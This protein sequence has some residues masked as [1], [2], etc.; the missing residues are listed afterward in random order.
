MKKRMLKTL[1]L[2]CAMA[3]LVEVFPLTSL[4]ET[5]RRTF[6][7]AVTATTDAPE[8]IAPEPGSESD[9]RN[10]DKS[11]P[12]Y[13]SRIIGEDITRRERGEKHFRKEDGSFVQVSYGEPVHYEKN[14][15]WEE[16]DNTL[17]E[18]TK[19]DGT[20]YLTNK[21]S[22]VRVELP[23]ATGKK[24]PVKVSYGKHTLSWTMAG[25]SA[26]KPMLK[27]P[28]ELEKQAAAKFSART[29]SP[30]ATQEVLSEQDQI[31]KENEIKTEL[32]NK[33][34]AVIYQDVLPFADVRYDV[35]SGGIKESVI[36]EKLPGQT[37]Y[38]FHMAAP[39]LSAVLR[40][41]RSVVF[42]DGD[43]DHPVFT[44][45]APYMFDAKEAYSEAITVRLDKT[46]EGWDYT[47][48]PDRNWL[49]DPKRQ[50]PVT[51][52]P[53]A[54]LSDESNGVKNIYTVTNE[55]GYETSSITTWC[56]VGSY[57]DYPYRDK[58][59]QYRTYVKL[60]DV[61]RRSDRRVV[62][63]R[64]KL[65]YSYGYGTTNGLQINMHEVTGAWKD[66]PGWSNKPAYGD[67]VDYAITE[68]REEIKNDQ[69]IIYTRDKDYFDF[70][71][72]AYKLSQNGGTSAEPCVVLI[73]SNETGDN[74]R[75]G[76]CSLKAQEE[77]RPKVYVDYRDVK[78]MEDYWTYT[79]LPS[80][81]GGTTMVNNATGNVVSVHP[82]ASAEGNR[83]PVNLTLVFNTYRKPSSTP[84]TT[85]IGNG[86]KLNYQMRVESRTDSTKYPYMFTDGDGT[87]HYFYKKDSK[88]VDED[89]LGLTLT[90]GSTAAEKYTIK[91]KANGTM[92]F[93]SDGNLRVMKNANSQAATVTFGTGSNSQR[94]E[95][96]TDGSGRVFTFQYHASNPLQLISVAEPSG[97]KIELLSGT[98]L[99]AI[100]EPGG[101]RTKFE[102]TSVSGT[103]ALRS[104]CVDYARETLLSYKYGPKPS[105][106]QNIAFL[107]DQYGDRTNFDGNTDTVL[108]SSDLLERYEFTYGADATTV[109]DKAGRKT[110]YS[111]NDFG[112]TVSVQDSSS[113]AATYYEYGMPGGEN[114]DGTQNKVLTSS[115][116]QVSYNNYVKNHGFDSSAGNWTVFSN[117]SG[118]T[119]TAAYDSTKGHFGKGSFKINQQSGKPG[120]VWCSQDITSLGTATYT[121]SGYVNTG[122]TTLSGNEGA[123]I[124]IE[125][126]NRTTGEI[127]RT[128]KSNTTKKTGT[129]E[130]QRL[131]VSVSFNNYE[132]LRIFTG[133]RDGS[134]GSLWL[135][136]FQVDKN[137][138]VN[139]YN[140]L[141]DS[142]M[143]NGWTSWTTGAPGKFT[144]ASS[145]A[146][147]P[148]VIGFPGSLASKHSIYQD[149]KVNGSQGDVFC[150][151]GYAKAFSIPQDAG[152]HGS[153]NAPTFRL[154][155]E[156]YNGSTKLAAKKPYYVEFNPYGLDWQYSAGRI[157]AP[158][159]YD[160]VRVQLRY[161][162]NANQ[163][164]FKS[165]YLNKEEFG[166]TYVYDKN[167]NVTSTKDLA[168]TQSNF[169]YRN[170]QLSKM[171]NPTGS[172]YTYTD[173]RNTKNM[174][175]A[176][177]T[178]SGM[179]YRVFYD[180]YGNPTTAKTVS[181]K[182][183]TSSL[184]TSKTYML[185]NDYSGNGV[186]N[187]GN[188]DGGNVKNWRF[189]IS[190]NN[191][192]W[193]LISTGEAGVYKL[194]RKDNSS[195]VMTVENNST[196]NNA[197]IKLKKD[198]NLDG[199]KFKLQY[200]SSDGTYH[201]RTKISG[202]AKCVDSQP[203]TAINTDE[204]VVLQQYTY[205]AADDGQKWYLMEFDN[206][207]V[208][209]GPAYIESKT[210]YT[211][212]GNLPISQKDA[213]GKVTSY[214][215]DE[216]SGLLE[217]STDPRGTQTNYTYD[218]NT[219]DLKS[220]V[221]TD[222]S[223]NELSRVNYSYAITGPAIGQIA[224]VGNNSSRYVLHHDNL[225]RSTGVSIG[226]RRLSTLTYNSHNM[227]GK[228][229]YGN[230]GL[231]T[232]WH[233]SLDRT[234]RLMKQSSSSGAAQ[235]F[236]YYYNANG[237]LGLQKDM[238]Q[239]T[240]TR[241]TYDTA[242]RM[243]GMNT[244]T[245]A[246]TDGGALKY[247]ETYTYESKTNRI[248][249][250]TQAF[251]ASESYTGSYRY[252]ST[253]NNQ[254]REAVY[255][256]SY[257]G[258][259]RLKREF[260]ALGRRTKSTIYTGSTSIPT[261]YTYVA[262]PR[263]NG[264]T[265]LLSTVSTK[266]V[267]WKYEY[268]DAGNITKVYKNG[269]EYATYT[270]DALG[271]LTH[272]LNME[273]GFS[274]PYIYDSHGNITRTNVDGYD[275]NYS[276][277]DS[278]WG[279][280]LTNFNGDSITYDP[281]GNPLTYR[282]GMSFEWQNGRELAKYKYNGQV[283]ATY[284]YNDSGIR[285]SKTVDGHTNNMILSGD[286]VIRDNPTGS[287]YLTYLYDEAGTRYG[288]QYKNGSS[289]S[290]Y[291]YVYNG[292]G[293]V[294]GILNSSG[295]LVAEYFYDA[296][297]HIFNIKDGSG[298]LI[299]SSNTTH[300]AN[301]NP[302][303]Y[304]GY[305][306]DTESGLYYLNSRYYDPYT[307]RFINADKII[308]NRN[309][310]GNNVFS[311]CQNNPVLYKDDSG[312]S[313]IAALLIGV[314]ICGIMVG[315]TSDNKVDSK[316]TLSEE[317]DIPYRGTPGSHVKSPDGKK[318]RV[319]GPDGLPDRD[320]HHTNHGNSKQHPYIPHD[321]DWGFDD[322]GAWQPGKGY[323][324]PEGPLLPRERAPSNEY[325]VKLPDLSTF[326]PSTGDNTLGGKIRDFIDIFK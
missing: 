125:V 270:Y 26:A 98:T 208:D 143:K 230:G 1:A 203:G 255:G 201:L 315:V 66:N 8:D 22:D 163:V 256:V 189:H 252:G 47:I 115:K 42:Y 20:P 244:N 321:H 159:T 44:V 149:V 303:R 281:I 227:I 247:G 46:A 316:I 254:I 53:S 41:D 170:D 102:Y 3:M 297:G 16:I 36:L 258:V 312:E 193:K 222:G 300:I 200:N 161:D 148:S 285:T 287:I 302:F 232:Y 117:T 236:Y 296:W 77:N 213:R 110:V 272:E 61:M 21:S 132:K 139:T 273:G 45:E 207:H 152:A 129:S 217:S 263:E 310:L 63:A 122:G 121:I 228:T 157:I 322:N 190:N 12:V 57:R 94:I 131:A 214:S 304:R 76:Y 11:E 130:W 186:D 10:A 298:N 144:E 104:V 96:I 179:L 55:P 153:R 199:Q 185:I 209:A 34:A 299:S 314:L 5:T 33:K 172:R 282:D 4:A 290:Y 313:L 168:D 138:T 128:A 249:S 93:N 146:T 278:E 28:A 267:T 38:T 317:N 73:S 198:A 19:A 260:D 69:L 155:L 197:N 265:T 27:Q 133:V 107:K 84:P 165:V 37:S 264:T 147:V 90:V 79:S 80:G 58:A 246:D 120:L 74:N 32:K 145:G 194:A 231:T 119:F 182:R 177:D 192:Y 54:T 126:V 295:S 280:L 9:E 18:K 187:S 233:D 164:R 64:L 223:S 184:S 275:R 29:A 286:T 292:Q 43:T 65:E 17:V 325:S 95:K 112:Q 320:R 2:S 224:T 180:S 235:N 134:V 221:A 48:T 218:S 51:I 205:Y 259:E 289:I 70:T 123:I 225:G 206:Q 162:F 136:D 83:M 210:E 212:N 101:H 324:S 116:A 56:A 188:A 253:S 72:L 108:N 87:D 151:G 240:R 216:K 229:S 308:D 60:P 196:A 293:D 191:Q 135:D 23:A 211:L 97:R 124:Y 160:R 86:W 219:K 31:K 307:C 279:D 266:D 154:E 250:Y 137:E 271:Q 127:L 141:E 59:Y 113:G 176:M 142:Y 245:G 158:G 269:K 261:S 171:L 150:L 277:T 306:Y 100:V 241:Y 68:Y 85:H 204:G 173:N 169:A 268:D 52:D 35:Q 257:A 71:R 91:D 305:Y 89:G 294:I 103:T 311:Y 92:I 40:E 220:V 239:N 166:Q 81:F 301:L 24:E 274:H 195:L 156:F 114:A 111:F 75:I 234:T 167:G 242:G 14:G 106:M 309:V 226:E 82:L 288:F 202:Y 175:F 118:Q 284:Q 49:E 248:S 326:S 174:E 181:M 7:A 15:Q 251:G 39:G 237:Q 178:D 78:G 13:E 318:E 319:Y 62:R 262:G 88:Y 140:M 30:A 99:S 215:Y 25:Q 291:Y 105:A 283:K 183:A 276:Y 50:Y 109:K 6:P 238:A 67:Q 243:I 323:K